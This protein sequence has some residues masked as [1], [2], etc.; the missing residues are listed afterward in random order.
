[1]SRKIIA[2]LR[3]VR[4]EEVSAIAEALI[5][6]GIDRIEVPLNSPDPL[7]S[8]ARLAVKFGRDATIGAGTVLSP[9]D[10]DRV[11]DAGGRLIVSPNAD[12]A[13]IRRTRE[14]GL[15]SYPGVFTATECFAAIAAGADALKF[16]PAFKLGTDGLTAISAV[17]P[18]GFPK[19]A[20]GGVDAP[21]FDAW[22]DAGADG[23]GLG[24]SLY[25]SGATTAEVG[26]RAQ[27]AV[28]AWDSYR[29]S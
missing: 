9:A 18:K 7:E 13:V 3:G 16:F 22:R 12:P 20:V 28:A 11:A 25:R 1:M 19:F 27:A 10:V 8:V 21:D 24:S 4:P 5:E 14:R 26:E 2:I 23:F 6:A 29:E 17:L 15:L